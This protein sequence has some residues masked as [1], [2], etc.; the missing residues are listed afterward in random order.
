[1]MRARTSFL[2]FAGAAVIVACAHDDKRGS[3]PSLPPEQRAAAGGGATGPA[4]YIVSD[5]GQRGGNVVTL[6]LPSGM[7]GMVVDKTRIVV[8]RGEPRVGADVTDET[9][10]KAAQIPQRLGG[11]YLFVTDSVLLR[12]ET[13]DGSLKPIARLPA[14][15]TDFSFAPKGV[16]AHLNNGERWALA[17]PSGERVAVEPVG[18][19]DVECLDDGRALA[20]NDQGT[21]FAS[22]DG[23][24][25]WTDITAHIKSSPQG[26]RR[27]D[28]DIW[29]FESGGTALHIEP[30]GH[31][32]SYDK[33][34]AEKEIEL[35]P[36]DPRW[37][38]AE[39]PL[40]MVFHAGASV[41]DSTALVV[42]DGDLVRVDVHTGE[43]VG[44][45]AGKLPPDAR[46]EAVPTSNDVLFACV[47]RQRNAYGQAGAFVASRTLGEEAPTIEQT[48]PNAGVFFAS[49]DGGLA[50]SGPCNA[51][52]LV[53]GVPAT[54]M[55]CVRQPGGSWQELDLS[56]F[57]GDGGAGPSDLTVARWV[58]RADG[59]VVALVMDPSPGIYD[60]RSGVVQ[61]LPIDVRDALTQGI[62]AQRFA[63]SKRG[64]VVNEGGG[65]VDWSWSFSA[66][67]SLRGWQRHGGIVEIGDDGKTTKSPY[68]FDI[69]ASG[70]Y[71]LGRTQDGRLYQSTDH[72]ASWAEVA[73]PPGANATLEL[74]G[75]SSAGCD[76][77]GFYR[78][79]WAVRAPRPEPAP[80][81][82][83]PAPD[84][85]RT[86]PMELACRPAGAASSRVLKRSERS[87]E[88]LGLG[89]VTRLPVSP[90]SGN[91]NYVRGPFVRGILNPVH[92]AA[93]NDSDT[94]SLRMMLFGYGTQRDSDVIEVM[95][96]NK[97]AS[98]LRRTMSFVAPF[99]PSASVKKGTLA[100][101]EVIAAGRSAGMTTEEI[102]QDDMTETGNLFP[103][104]SHD[105]NAPNDLAYH[106]ARG[107]LAVVRANER[108]R[109][110]VR[111]PQ[112]EGLVISGA[113]LSDA[114]SV[115]LELET[116]T[117]VGHV[118]KVTGSGVSDLFDISPTSS[119]ATYYPAN[120]DAIAINAKGDVAVLRTPSGSDPPSAIDPAYV[121]QPA[122]A[123]IAL[124]PWST[125]KLADDAS[126]KGDPGWRATV[127]AIGPWVRVTTPELRVDEAPMLA[128]V[129]WNDKRVCVEGVEVKLPNV[130]MRSGTDTVTASTWLVGR[131]GQFARVAI[132]EGFEWRQPLECSLV[133]SSP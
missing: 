16:L 97:A 81:P 68:A 56:Q 40:H 82:A 75:C 21:A 129:K 92:D 125:A 119:D 90:E 23:G 57:S 116:S 73:A 45:L 86:K 87:P 12:S 37:R 112:N 123:P 28:G 22:T 59:R 11:G 17:I 114:E 32:A 4:Q 133:A 110:V 83:A 31:V 115:F 74:L 109:V 80:K 36:K 8:A 130:T 6:Q 60:P 89:G 5:P 104:T 77:G 108:V 35:R 72:G 50:Y 44:V 132:G 49:D 76:L 24:V 78:V 41:D 39:A 94:P 88:D 55:V 13:F 95:G 43:I 105:A 100:M 69:V 128:R 54:A 67:G 121:I 7:L 85:R 127:A 102:L 10:K 2:V 84:V 58:P 1:M 66:T 62:T 3:T 70:A 64:Y 101:S 99:D 20:F 65:I 15:V 63:R 107:M 71:A 42:A 48:F 96:P 25:H 9:I 47:S 53:P 113:V 61:S 93:V 46:C 34:P 26:V 111:P 118:F 131:A 117:A 29:L 27:I 91:I 79:G 120:P 103:V 98:S 19:A 38:N 126:C 33:Q 18:A 122:L 52:A 30:D 51:Q 106:S 124:A 14:G